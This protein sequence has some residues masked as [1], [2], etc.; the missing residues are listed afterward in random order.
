MSLLLQISIS[1]CFSV[2][3]YFRPY[4]YML[5]GGSVL[6]FSLPCNCKRIHSFSGYVFV[7]M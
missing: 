7:Q 4:L 6:I 1:I 5:G 2:S 3:A